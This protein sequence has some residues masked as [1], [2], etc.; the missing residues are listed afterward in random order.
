MRRQS[1][2]R[3]AWL[4][5]LAIL[6][7][8]LMPLASTLVSGAKLPVDTVCSAAGHQTGGQNEASLEDSFAAH[9]KHC[10]Y[11]G[12]L[13]HLPALATASIDTTPAS[14]VTS[15]A[16]LPRLPAGVRHQRYLRRPSRAPPFSI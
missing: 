16:V 7:A 4:G 5:I 6:L 9:F 12:L 1:S 14:V 10:G 15:A 13:A 2:H 8:T 11:C 3:T